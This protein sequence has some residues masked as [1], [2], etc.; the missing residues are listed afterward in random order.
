MENAI[1]DLYLKYRNGLPE[2]T[3]LMPQS[4][5]NRKYYK[6]TNREGEVCVGTIG[7]EAREN[8]AFVSFTQSLN[9]AGLNVPKIL[10][11]DENC[12]VYL[13][14]YIEGPTLFEYLEKHRDANGDPDNTTI[15][16]YKKV[17]AELPKF[18]TIGAKVLDFDLCYPR[19]RFDAQSIIWDLNYFKYYFLKAT[20]TVFDEQLLE[21]DFQTLVDYLT[22]AECEYFLY[23]DFQSRNIIIGND[24]E[25]Y[26]VDY[27]GGRLGCL[28]YDIVSLLYDAKAGLKP[29]I[30]EMLLDYYIAEIGKYV[31]IDEKDFREM[32]NAFAYVRIMQAC[33][34][35]GY[36]GLYEGKQHFVKSIPLAM[37]NLAYLLDKQKLP[38]ETPELE[39]CLRSISTND[40]LLNITPKL[41]VTVMS[42][43]YKKGIPYDPTGNGGG[44][45]FDCRAI[46]N[47]GRY[48]EYKQLTGMD[49][50]VIDF[51]EK[52]P[53]VAEFEDLAQRM[54]D[55]SVRKYISRGF[56]NLSVLFGCT[57]GQHRS[58]Y[59]AERMAEYLRNK[60]PQVIVRL[61]HRE[62]ERKSRE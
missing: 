23:R 18:Q 52:E 44:F 12:H 33:G 42:F 29:E 4:G 35:Y 36:R 31:K 26:F 30:R 21:N 51:L 32:F 37:R 55:A 24:G 47:P 2:K 41:T 25:P 43:S 54:V 39:Q 22:K 57:G 27:Q 56:E 48:D 11:T 45:V 40:E 15:E 53:E 1:T 3:E 58:V 19:R 20:H 5:S 28:H 14:T 17:I 9:N 61:S 50:P 49:Q 7:Y 59:S 62:Q 16:L 38:I 6:I 8:K 34:A 46:P 13:Q 60:Y 10:A